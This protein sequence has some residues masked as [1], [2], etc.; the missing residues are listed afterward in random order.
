MKDYKN[1]K[2]YKADNL[3]SN[4]IEE[5]KNM[6]QFIPDVLSHLKD[7]LIFT[8]RL[9]LFV[10]YPIRLLLIYILIYF[11]Y[12][13]YK[14]QQINMLSKMDSKIKS[15]HMSNISDLEKSYKTFVD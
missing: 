15:R 3:N 6:I 7:L 2:E 1:F 4:Y 8:I 13:S 5:F 12:K 10:F 14:K 11:A 9:L